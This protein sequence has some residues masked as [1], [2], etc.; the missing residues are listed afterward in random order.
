MSNVSA[1]LIWEVARLQN[2]YLVKR[3]S[4]GGV[5]FSK[6]PLNLTN[7]HSRKFAGFVNDKAVGVVAAEKGGVEVISKKASAANKPASGRIS[8]VYGAN[9]GTRKTYKSIA[10]TVA[11]NGYRA[12]LL[13]FAVARASAI[14]KSQKPVKPS[15]VAKPRS[16]KQLAAASKA[17]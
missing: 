3:N 11:K 17:E 6:D 7:V 14:R 13:P 10:N 15:P 2:A 4:N 16:K 12:D 9:K 8:T 5:Q 1:D